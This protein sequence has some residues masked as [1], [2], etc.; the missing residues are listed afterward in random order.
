V[1]GAKKKGIKEGGGPGPW[2]TTDNNDGKE[3]VSKAAK[4]ERC[5]KKRIPSWDQRAFPRSPLKEDEEVGEMLRRK[6]EPS[7]DRNR[8]L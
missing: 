7:W 1:K 5:E 3:F 6:L 2:K 8:V 4:E